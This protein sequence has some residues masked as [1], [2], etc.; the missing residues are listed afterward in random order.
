MAVKLAH[1]AVW[2]F[3]VGCIVGLP[4]AGW[5][6]RFDI[7]LILAGLV[8]FECGVLALNRGRCPLTGIAA[9]FTND[10]SPAF[11]IYLPAWLAAR[12][13]VIFGT[14][15]ALNGLVVLLEWLIGRH[16]L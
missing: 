7:A 3:F 4:I 8:L 16:T 13:K 10:R 14:L 9:Q 6:R 2:A 15:F 5:Y 1:T 11:D 12:N